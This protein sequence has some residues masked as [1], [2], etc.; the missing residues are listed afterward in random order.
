AVVAFAAIASFRARAASTATPNSPDVVA[1]LPF[2]YTGTG[3]VSYLG[4][5]M[6]RLLTTNLNGAGSLRVIDPVAVQRALDEETHG[7]SMAGVD[8]AQTRHIADRFGAG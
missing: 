7:R 3:G 4:D 1:V 5:G 2:T 8:S 6:G